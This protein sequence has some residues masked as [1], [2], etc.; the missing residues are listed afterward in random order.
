MY[1]VPIVIDSLRESIESDMDM[2]RVYFGTFSKKKTS[3]GQLSL[4]KS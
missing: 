1:N 2:K 4:G 3:I